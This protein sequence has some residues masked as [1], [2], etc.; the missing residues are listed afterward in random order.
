MT[1]KYSVPYTLLSVLAHPDDESFGMGGTLALYARRGV[2]VHL[3]CATRGE[4]GDVDE[5]YLEGFRTKADRRESELR[6]AAMKLGLAGVQFLGYRDSGMPGAPDNQHPQALIAAS[7]DDVA[8][9]VAHTIRE[10]RPQVVLTF[11]PIGGYKHPDHIAIH[12]ATVR[13]FELAGRAEY[14][15][16]LDPYQ[17]EK[18]Y[19]HVI[20]RGILRFAV[21][22]MPLFGKDPRHF[23]RNGDIDLASLVNDGDFP[24]HAVI[25][26]SPVANAKDDASLCHA[27]QLGGASLRRGPMRWAQ[28]LFGRKEHFMRAY[29]P[30]KNGRREIDLF[31]GV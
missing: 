24:I 27:S 20:P 13:A 12:N 5:T 2:A 26:Y 15:D 30:P 31:S 7:L 11:D 14:Q 4:A 8:A 22:V 28:T 29:P 10:L 19:Y 16:G 9:K 18:L 17:P 21:K 1:E 3:I 25:D 23:G 6:C